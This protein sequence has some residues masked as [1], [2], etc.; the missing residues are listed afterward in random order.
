MKGTTAASA[1]HAPPARAEATPNKGITDAP[2]AR[3]L[4]RSSSGLPVLE[5]HRALVQLCY[6][7]H[8]K[9][10]RSP[11][12]PSSEDPRARLLASFSPRIGR[13]Q[14]VQGG[15]A[16]PLFDSGCGIPEQRNRGR[17]KMGEKCSWHCCMHVPLR[18]SGKSGSSM[19]DWS[20][21]LY[22]VPL[23]IN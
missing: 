14:L 17:D 18:C 3:A 7:P 6:S 15:E 4:R 16:V 13:Q 11:V 20:R 21:A 10:S 22:P 12:L 19:R 5:I 9:S 23:S 1:A 8:R 2:T